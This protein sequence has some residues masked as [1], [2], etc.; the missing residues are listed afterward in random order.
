M[1]TIK[2]IPTPKKFSIELTEAELTLIRSALV[3][4]RNVAYANQNGHGMPS[5][6]RGA[7]SAEQQRAAGELLT[8]IGR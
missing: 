7:V 5:M 6:F 3:T 8:H 4:M 2:E 1:A